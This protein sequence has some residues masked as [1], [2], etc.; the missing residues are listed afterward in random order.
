MPCLKTFSTGWQQATLA[1][2]GTSLPGRMRPA[3]RGAQSCPLQL[4]GSGHLRAIIKDQRLP[5]SRWQLTQTGNGPGIEQGCTF[6]SSISPCRAAGYAHAFVMGGQC[7]S[8]SRSTDQIRHPVPK[9]DTPGN[10]LRPLTDVSPPGQA[11]SAPAGTALPP[12]ASVGAVQMAMG[13]PSLTA[14]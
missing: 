1:F 8:A 14:A 7:E 12:A 6:L 13:S 4:S 2:V 5:K 9:A 11:V 3:K 10:K